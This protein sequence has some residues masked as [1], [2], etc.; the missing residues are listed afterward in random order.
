MEQ[1][2]FAGVHL[3]DRVGRGELD[4]LLGRG[5]RCGG[6]RCGHRRAAGDVVGGRHAGD[7]L[8]AEQPGEVADGGEVVDAGEEAL[9]AMPG[10]DGVGEGAVAVLDLG[11]VLPAGDEERAEGGD[12]RHLAGQPAELE[13]AGFVDDDEQRLVEAAAGDVPGVDGVLEVGE[14]AAEDGG[15]PL[16]LG[17]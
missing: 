5:R 6:L 15:E 9:G 2:G 17:L 14:Q 7:V 1:D 10:Q 8:G 11:E 16:E 13:L 4:A 12:G 3:A